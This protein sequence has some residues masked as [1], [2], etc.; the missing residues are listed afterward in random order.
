MNHRYALLAFVLCSLA[1]SPVFAREGG[2]GVGNGGDLTEIEIINVGQKLKKFIAG[3]KG[4]QAFPEVDAARFAKTVDET[5]I[6][7]TTE[8]VRD[9]ANVPRSAINY[10]YE[11]KNVIRFNKA[12]ILK[13]EDRP[14]EQVT[15][16]F[17]EYLN[18]MGLELTSGSPA[19]DARP[20]SIYPISA[21]VIPFR[22]EI[23]G[24]K[25]DDIKNGKFLKITCTNIMR[26]FGYKTFLYPDGRVVFQNN[27]YSPVGGG[28]RKVVLKTLFRGQ[29]EA[30]QFKNDHEISVFFKEPAPR[31]KTRHYQ[32]DMVYRGKDKPGMGL[33]EYADHDFRGENPLN[34]HASVKNTQPL[35]CI[36]WDE[37]KPE[38][39]DEARAE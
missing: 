9:Y 25:L 16:I 13:Y 37:A 39:T 6:K 24:T 35:R 8:A 5:L 21:R 14:D 22:E 4:R 7:V 1:S 27:M 2:A 33:I 20:T 29:Y 34:R 32:L 30:I 12:A 11:G 38:N 18:L 31:G 19:P 10:V 3:E 17:H 23:L 28:Y 15:L 26:P 36:F